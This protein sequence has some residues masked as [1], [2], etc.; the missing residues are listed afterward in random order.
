MI[1]KVLLLTFAAGLISAPIAFPA[2]PGCKAQWHWDSSNGGCLWVSCPVFLECPQVDGTQTSYCSIRT[3]QDA[4]GNG[5]AA[6][7]C[8]AGGG[9]PPC[10]TVFYWDGPVK[11]DGEF[12]VAPINPSGSPRVSCDTTITPCATPPCE[13]DSTPPTPDNPNVKEPCDC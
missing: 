5:W 6:C 9:M 10:W 7:R 1:A 2:N 12:G 4:D 13:L 11:F 3:G 8:D